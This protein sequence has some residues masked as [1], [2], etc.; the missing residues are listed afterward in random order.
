ML[1]ENRTEDPDGRS[2]GEDPVGRSIQPEENKSRRE[3]SKLG[4][5]KFEKA[6]VGENHSADTTTAD[7]AI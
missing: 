2:Q 5:S 6:V 3:T 4:A 1:E 7:Q